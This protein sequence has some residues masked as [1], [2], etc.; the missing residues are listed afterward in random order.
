MV[1]RIT[2]SKK[3][4][5]NNESSALAHFEELLSKLPDPRR[6]QG[7][8]YPLRSVVV[9]GLM[10]CVCGCDNA[11]SMNE[12]GKTNEEWLK[13]FLDLPHG[14][15]SQ[16][17][18]LSVF[19]SLEPSAFSKVFEQ[20]SRWLMLRLHKSSTHIAIDGKCVRRS[21]DKSKEQPSIHMVSA[22]TSDADLVLAQRKTDV[23]SN[24]ITAIPK[25]LEA[26]DISG[27]TITIDAMGCQTKI[28]ESIIEGGAD[29][30]LSV[31]DN[32]E[33][34]HA[35]IKETFAEADDDRLRSV[36][37]VPKPEIQSFSE[38]EKGHGRIEI[39]T[40][41]V[42]QQLSWVQTRKRWASLGTLIEVTRER[43]ELSTDKTSKEVSHYIASQKDISA[44]TAA[45]HIR[46]H[47]GIENKLH[48]VLDMAFREDEARHR[49]KNA[50]QNMATLRHFALNIIKADKT[51]KVGVAIARQRAGWDRSYLIQLLTAD[52]V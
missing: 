17:V 12:W 43:H 3:I 27:T 36:D 25:L 9:I 6:R 16:D 20:W 28:A 24:E 30:I 35:E 34:L 44:K 45:R 26:L 41:R 37:E 8:R 13:T 1:P 32:Q 5:Q 31:K 48:W 10:A 42:T 51:R 19:A 39:R 18:F 7:L 50:A 38:T 49:A 47:W 40:V 15:P 21:H 2:H 46:S 4:E 23:K 33:T 52:K 11:E 14:S 29:Y 22:W